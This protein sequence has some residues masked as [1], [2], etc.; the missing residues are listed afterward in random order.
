MF[1]HRNNDLVAVR[2]LKLLLAAA[3]LHAHDPVTTKLTWSQEI[4]RIFVRRCMSCHREGGSAPMALTAYSEARPWAKAIK[5]EVLEREMPP[6]GAVK[7]FGEFRNDGA[8]TQDEIMRIAE[9]VEGGAPEGDPVYLPPFPPFEKQRARPSSAGV[10]V[11]ATQRLTKPMRLGALRPLADVAY[12]EAAVEMPD[13][14][15]IPLIALRNYK[16]EYRRTFELA[17]PL[18]LPAGSLIRTGTPLQ[19][20]PASTRA[21]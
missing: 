9:W 4:S 3:L 18:D 6:W 7:G 17:E 8:L 5:E 1:H 21:H 12:A 20:I 10:T 16:K 19:L 15:V 2:I 11:N 14:R 13:G